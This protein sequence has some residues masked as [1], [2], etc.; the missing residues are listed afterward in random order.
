MK[1][2]LVL[3]TLLTLGL[4]AI[5]GIANAQEG[6][7]FGKVFFDYY[8]DFSSTKL[9]SSLIHGN[10]GQKNGFEFTRVYFGYDQDID[11]MFGARFL[12]DADNAAGAFRPYVKNAYLSINCKL[13]KG[14]KW[15]IGMI[16][17]PFDAVPEQHWGYR[18]IFKAP[19][20][21]FGIGN[22]ADLGIGA[23]GMWQD[24]YQLEF[25]VVNGE[26]YKNLE[27]NPYKLIEF[28]PTIFLLNKALTVSAFGSFKSLND[29]SSST[30]FAGMAG[31]DHKYFRIGG[32]IG[33]NTISKATVVAGDVKDNNKPF[34]AVWLHVKPMPKLT[35]FVRFDRYE[36]N[37]NV[38]QDMYSWLIFGADFHPNKNFRII[39]N[40]QMKMFEQEDNSTTTA[41]DEHASINT[42]Y[43]TFEYGW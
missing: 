21:A 26:G 27:N 23:K 6:K 24:K 8:H 19:M 33:Q 10:P 42:F 29:S 25:A 41:I 12:I 39:P 28:R 11:Q 4:S 40:V 36:P 37:S 38:G 43:V 2:Q 34:F 1:K 32:E 18:S 5:L 13:V 30:I 35:G 3:F 22:T 9:D 7:L 15:Y 20:D 17:T 14:L 16:P 31:Y